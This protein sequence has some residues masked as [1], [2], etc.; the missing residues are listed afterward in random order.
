MYVGLPRQ[1]PFAAHP[2]HWKSESAQRPPCAVP[3][4]F[5]PP[6]SCEVTPVMASRMSSVAEVARMVNGPVLAVNR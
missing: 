2:A 1:S 4:A 5:R 3:S 6:V